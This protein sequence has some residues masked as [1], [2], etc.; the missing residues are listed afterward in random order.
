MS[1]NGGAYSAVG[2]ATS[3]VRAV[4]SS[5]LTDNANTTQ[6]LSTGT[7]VAGRV[8]DVDGTMTSTTSIPTNSVTDFEFM[9]Q[10]VAADLANADTLDFRVYR[11]GTEVT[12]YTNTPRV[13]VLKVTE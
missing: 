9:V 5:N 7:F 2:S 10:L 13:T 1:K 11:S 8:D 4:G 12:T 3:S 6:Q